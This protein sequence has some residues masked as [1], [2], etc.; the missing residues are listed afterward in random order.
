MIP[1]EIFSKTCLNT[2]KNRLTQAIIT[3]SFEKLLKIHNFD[4]HLLR[5]NNQFDSTT[6]H[7][8]TELSL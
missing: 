7:F 4:D 2:V 1:P 6:K 5:L 8:Y 3:I